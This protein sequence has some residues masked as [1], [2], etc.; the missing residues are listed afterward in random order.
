MPGKP[1]APRPVLRPALA[2]AVAASLAGAAA[3]ALAQAATEAAAAGWERCAAQTDAAQRLACYDAWAQAQAPMRPGRPAATAAAAPASVASAPAPASVAR[4]DAA[5]QAAAPAA[6]QELVVRL[7][8]G[9]GCRNPAYSELSRF[10]EL[11]AGSSCDTFGLRGYRPVSLSA[12]ASDSVNTQPSSGNPLN[13]AAAPLP[14]RRSETRIQLSVRTK[15][16]QGLLTHGQPDKR[17]S[18]WFAYSQQ[19]Y[20]QLFNDPLSRPFRNTDHEPEL[21][22]V[23][24]LS[25][26][27]PGGWQLRYGGVGLVHQSNGQSLPL[28]RSWNRVYLMAGGELDRRARVQLRAWQRLPETRVNDDNPDIADYIG[29]AELQGYWNLDARNTLGLT[30]RHSLRTTAHGSLRLEWLRTLGEN[31]SRLRFHVQLFSGYGDSLIDFN[32]RRTVLGV[33]LSLVD[34]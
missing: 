9:E 27:L 19:S 25:A 3:S 29:R 30:L 8:P 10:W 34:F 6:E 20:W 2:A 14:Y 16:A 23:Y 18:L 33:G 5:P 13:N 4:Q 28:S 1:T 24:P 26:P 31:D 21:I 22:Y 7:V 17:D 11:E 12:I 32:R 15:L